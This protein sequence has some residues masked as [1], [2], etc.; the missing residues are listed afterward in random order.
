MFEQDQELLDNTTSAASTDDKKARQAAQRKQASASRKAAAVSS[1]ID[2]IKQATAAIRAGTEAI[3]NAKMV[4]QEMASGNPELADAVR[5][6]ISSPEGMKEITARVEKQRA[7]AKANVDHTA[8][9]TQVGNKYLKDLI[10]KHVRGMSGPDREILSGRL[11]A[12]ITDAKNVSN[13]GNNTTTVTMNLF[14]KREVDGAVRVSQERIVVP[15]IKSVEERVVGVRNTLGKGNW[16]TAPWYLEYR[17]AAK[18]LTD[19]CNSLRVKVNVEGVKSCPFGVW[20]ALER[21]VNKQA[22]RQDIDYVP[23]W[24]YPNPQTP[25][26]VE[27]MTNEELAAGLKAGTR[28]V[29]LSSLHLSSDPS[30]LAS[31]F[32]EAEND[33][34]ELPPKIIIQPSA[35]RSAVWGMEARLSYNESILEYRGGVV[36]SAPVI[37]HKMATVTYK[38]K[39]YEILALTDGQQRLTTVTLTLGKLFPVARGVT[40]PDLVTGDT[41]TV[42]VYFGSNNI[43]DLD[44]MEELYRTYVQDCRVYDPRMDVNFDD[45]IIAAL[46]SPKHPDYITSCEKVTAAVNSCENDVDAVFVRTNATGVTLTAEERTRALMPLSMLAEAVPL[47]Q[48][49]NVV[50]TLAQLKLTSKVD[51]K[52]KREMFSTEVASNTN[53]IAKVGRSKDI[54]FLARVIAMLHH[55]NGGSPANATTF[56]EV[57]DGFNKL[58]NETIKRYMLKA[59]VGFDLLAA[60]PN[61]ITVDV[62]GDSVEAGTTKNSSALAAA[63][64]AWFGNFIVE[65]GYEDVNLFLQQLGDTL[66]G[67]APGV[68]M[69]NGVNV[70]TDLLQTVR[71]DRGVE[72]EVDAEGKT[73]RPAVYGFNATVTS[74]NSIARIGGLWNI[75]QSR[76]VESLDDKLGD[77]PVIATGGI[78]L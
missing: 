27:E 24:T 15:N 66:D 11:Q 78:S 40:K 58:S 2:N 75:I 9:A 56:S 55:L 13:P 44:R 74:I 12:L 14:L 73:V 26:K 61:W 30:I 36:A 69:A 65:K 46:T 6:Y 8:I 25:Y 59:R 21:P 67:S 43:P 17:E 19:T 71:D 45:N 34:V 39:V 22:V 33:G 41:K 68:M 42:D 48:T 32:I 60:N 50:A 77:T 29:G 4:L 10:N 63:L 49:R 70:I 20:Q 72:K 23:V 57:I 28:G 3:A 76:M 64:A 16:E 18:A 38:G 62:V 1:G 52:M 37:L 35:Q 7:A 51:E 47:L 5:N 31:Y 54:G 53:T